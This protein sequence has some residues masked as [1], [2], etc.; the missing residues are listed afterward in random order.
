MVVATLSTPP[1][2]VVSS[3]SKYL[4][5][6][7]P[8]Q[9]NIR[10]GEGSEQSLSIPAVLRIKTVRAE[11]LDTAL[12]LWVDCRPWR[13]KQNQPGLLTKRPSRQPNKAAPSLSRGA[14]R[15]WSASI[16]SPQ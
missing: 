2:V 12:V 7:H 10:K 15:E 9:L 8:A 14:R 4:P 6:M 5:T 1:S 11:N 16:A 13:K 3:G